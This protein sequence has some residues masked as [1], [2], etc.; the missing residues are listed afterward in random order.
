MVNSTH[1]SATIAP[2]EDARKYG[3][4]SGGGGTCYSKTLSLLNVGDRVWVNVPG[5]GYVGVGR[6]LEEV[7]PAKDFVV[8]TPQ[9]EQPALSVLSNAASLQKRAD[10][11]ELRYPSGGRR[12]GLAT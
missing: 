7:V 11:P 10:D 2:G 6:I 1:H 12:L 5:I 3:F 9:G 4:I 8:R